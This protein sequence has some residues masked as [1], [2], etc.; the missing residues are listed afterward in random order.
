MSLRLLIVTQPYRNS[1]SYDE[2]LF[3]QYKRSMII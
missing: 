1:I 3:N 2:E